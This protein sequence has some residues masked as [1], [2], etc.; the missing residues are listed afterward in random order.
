MHTRLTLSVAAALAAVLLAAG[1][2]AS[3]AEQ[4]PTSSARPGDVGST[5]APDDDAIEAAWLDDGRMF[6]IVTWGSSGCVPVV[7]EVAAEGQKVSVSLVQAP[8]QEM[9]TADYAARASIGALPE[10]VDPT[11]DVQFAVT[12]E[13]TAYEVELDGNPA[14][15]GT[16]GEATEYAPSAGWFDDEGIV[17]LTWGSSGCPP[18]VEN[19]EVNDAGATVTFQTEDRACTMDMAP[20]ATI[21]DVGEHDDDID[22]GLTLVGDNLDGTVPVLGH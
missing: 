17:L 16:P 10:G 13:D 1:C 8:G 15:T 4:S 21:L 6:A 19:V 11:Q 7:D 9:C 22:F 12:L 3:P 20:R 14:L 2:S 18:I 5:Q